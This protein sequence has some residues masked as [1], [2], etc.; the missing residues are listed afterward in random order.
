MGSRKLAGD[1][2]L[3][4]VSQS[5]PQISRRLRASSGQQANSLHAGSSRDVDG[6]G[7]EFEIHVVIALDECDALYSTGKDI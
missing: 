6:V 1:D 2:Y 4:R 5:M 3:N 7:D